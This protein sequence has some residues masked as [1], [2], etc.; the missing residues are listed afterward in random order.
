MGSTAPLK[1]G[2]A[3]EVEIKAYQPSYRH[4]IPAK[5]GENRIGFP[6]DAPP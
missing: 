2:G 4:S 5:A 6:A 3:A 1:G